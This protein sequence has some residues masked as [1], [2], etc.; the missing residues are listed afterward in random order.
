[1]RTSPAAWLILLL[2]VAVGGWAIGRNT[3]PKTTVL[4]MGIA[5]GIIIGSPLYLLIAAVLGS[6]SSRLT[7]KSANHVPRHQM[8]SQQPLVVV[9]MESPEKPPKPG[10]AGN[11]GLSVGELPP[12]HML[13]EE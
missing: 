13:G 6:M 2:L 7:Q 3:S 9:F 4:L 1:M 11:K 5:I 12:V 10:E 8:V